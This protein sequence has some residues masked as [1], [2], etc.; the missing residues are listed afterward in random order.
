MF[1]ISAAPEVYQHVIQ[2]VLAG[3]E[4]AENISDGIIVHGKGVA[5]HDRKLKEVLCLLRERG[6]T[7]NRVK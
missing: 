2:E 3:C 7:L 6:L 4:G 1:G 5:D